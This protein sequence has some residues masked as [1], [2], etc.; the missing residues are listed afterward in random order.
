MDNNTGIG[1]TFLDQP[2]CISCNR[3]GSRTVIYCRELLFHT[4]RQQWLKWKTQ[5]SA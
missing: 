5:R 3:L 4:K 2:V 1:Y